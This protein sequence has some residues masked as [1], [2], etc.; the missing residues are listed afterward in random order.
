MS[1]VH[2]V[3]SCVCQQSQDPSAD[4]SHCED[5]SLRPPQGGDGGVG[6]VRQW[7]HKPEV[8]VKGCCNYSAQVRVVGVP[9]NLFSQNLH[10]P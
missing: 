5:I 7:R 3:V 8:L 6:R 9:C 1:Y 10:C 2:C 4:V